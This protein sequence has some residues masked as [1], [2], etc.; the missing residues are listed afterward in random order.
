MLKIQIKFKLCHDYSRHIV[1]STKHAKN[2][3]S[4]SLTH[5]SSHFYYIPLL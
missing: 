1:N 2:R 4:E 3:M 5:L